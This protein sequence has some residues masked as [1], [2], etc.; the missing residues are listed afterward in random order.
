VYAEEGMTLE[1]LMAFTV[2]PDNERQEQIWEA[3][4]RSYSKEP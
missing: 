4:Q 1:Q 3:L 2:N